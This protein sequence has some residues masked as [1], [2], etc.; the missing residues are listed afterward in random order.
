MPRA[1][2]YFSD[3][4]SRRGSNSS[5]HGVVPNHDWHMRHA[6]PSLGSWLKHL[7]VQHPRLSQERIPA[8]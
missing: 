8:E 6:C 2:C 4:C 5:I 1:N 3:L 7:Q